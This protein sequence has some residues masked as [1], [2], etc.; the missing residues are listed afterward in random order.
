MGSFFA[1]IKAGTLGGLLYIG[2]LAAFNVGQ[3][4]AFKGVALNLISQNN[5]TVCPSLNVTSTEACFNSVVAW[6]IPYTALL[7]FFVAV[8]FAGIF[9]WSFESFPGKSPVAKGEVAAVLV[10]IGLI[11]GG[12]YGVNLGS[13]ATILLIVFMVGWTGLFGY[14][15]GRLYS[16]YTRAV[17]IESAEEKLVKVMVDGKDYTGRIRTFAHTSVHKVRAEIEEGASFKGWNVS[18]GVTVED[19]RS[20]ETIMEVNGDGLLKA[21]CALK[22]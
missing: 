14:I 11:L 12:L 1:G 20:F 19:S 9:G 13:I 5:P 7:G 2:G 3:L 22:S 8:F 17:R 4:Y 18:G 6:Y 10:V 16:R 15:L 21:Q